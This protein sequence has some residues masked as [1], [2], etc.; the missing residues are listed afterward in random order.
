MVVQCVACL[1]SSQD[2]LLAFLSLLGVDIRRVPCARDAHASIAEARGEK[3]GFADPL[4]VHSQ[5]WRVHPTKRESLTEHR[6]VHEYR[7]LYR[8]R[9]STQC[10]HRRGRQADGTPSVTAEEELGFPTADRRRP[11]EDDR[12]QRA[13]NWTSAPR[14]NCLCG[15]GY[16]PQSACWH[17][18]HPRRHLPV[19]HYFERNDPLAPL[20][21]RIPIAAKRRRHAGTFLDG[22]LHGQVA[23]PCFQLSREGRQRE[24]HVSYRARLLSM[25]SLGDH[26]GILARST[27]CCSSTL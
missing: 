4:Q 17:L 19:S 26:S 8:R 24:A 5:S 27:R 20:C 16:R 14:L 6:Y 25:G 7:K 11:H 21:V 2:R 23:M 22:R 3:V 18:V 13:A 1:I 15:R 9:C 12:G 10:S